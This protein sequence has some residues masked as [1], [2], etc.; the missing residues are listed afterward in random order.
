[1][2]VVD[3]PLVSV[4][5]LNH[6]GQRFLSRCLSSVL[7]TKYPRFEVVLVDN[8]STDESLNIAQREFGK[9]EKLKIVRLGKNLGF[10]PANNIGFQHAMGDYIVFL[11]NDTS[12]N[13]DWLVPLV[14]TLE[15]DRT[16]GLAQSVILAMDDHKVQTAGWLVSDYWVFLNPIGS[17]EHWRDDCYPDVFEISYASG[18]A[19]MTRRELIHDIGLFDPMYFW[20]YDDTYISFKTWINGKR[21]VTV[22]KSKVHHIGAGTSGLWNFF[23]AKNDTICMISLILDVYWNLQDLAKALFVFSFNK[24]IVSFKEIAEHRKAV[25]FWGSVFAVCWI[26][27]NLRYIWKNRLKYWNR[28]RIDQKTLLSKM[29]R[30]NIPTSFYLVLPPAK[31]LW[32]H[33]LNETAKYRNSLIRMR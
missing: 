24:V 28:A 10:G 21:V 7:E 27:K 25:R 31:L 18:T 16:I 20:F 2:I 17:G 5:I 13:S 15:K 22:S 23:V 33:F 29:I 3:E 8:G 6:N 4:I 1:M 14:D 12:V 30:I 11:N 32:F 19:M 26:L 9:N